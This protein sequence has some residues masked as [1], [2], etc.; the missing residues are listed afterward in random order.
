MELSLIPDEVSHDPFTAFEFARRWDIALCELRY[1]YRWR[2]PLC[3]PWV[4]D[5]MAAAVNAYDM[6]VT[7]ISP[8]LF[9]PVLQVDG[10]SR[11]VRLS[12]PE[13]VNR[14]IDVH[15]PLA[16]EY[17]AKLGTRHLIVFALAREPGDAADAPPP[18][19]VVD[20]LGR[21]AAKAKEA[22]ATLLLENGPGTWADTAAAIRALIEA[23]GSEHLR[24]TWDPAN[25]VHAGSAADPVAD[26]FPVVRPFVRNVHVKDAIR[27]D[28]RGRWVMLGDG[29]VDWPGQLRALR[30]AGYRG[31]LTLEPHLQYESPIDL[32]ATVETFVH[33][34]RALVGGARP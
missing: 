13:E 32:V 27:K 2:V 11:P 25:V 4:A 20:A 7:A 26:E 6:T 12:L 8:G 16:L 29:R 10:S 28:G 31:V 15:L 14:H 19:G 22:G 18:A 30:E 34:A 5:R 1:A 21:A 3:P 33:R 23:V 17:A 9:K 24:L